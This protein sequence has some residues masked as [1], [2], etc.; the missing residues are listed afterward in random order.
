MITYTEAN[1]QVVVSRTLFV[2]KNGSD[3]TGLP[4]R[5]DKPFLTIEGAKNS[6]LAFFPV[7]TQSNRVLIVVESGNY[8]DQIYIEDFIDYDLGNSV[9]DGANASIPTVYAPST[10]TY[11]ATTQGIPNCII[12]GNATIRN[13]FP[14]T[15]VVETRGDCKILMYCNILRGEVFEAI[16]MR[17]GQLVVYANII[18]NAIQNNDLRQVINLATSN[19]FTVPTLEVNGAKIYNRYVGC[20]NSVIEIYNGQAGTYNTNRSKLTLNNC[21][22]GNFSANR[23]AIDLPIVGTD[24]G[25]ADIYLTNTI[26]YGS[27]PL[28]FCISDNFASGVD[29]GDLTIYSYSVYSNLAY[30]LTNP[31]SQYLINAPTVNANVNFNNNV[32][33]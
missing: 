5:L 15:A 7:R 23:S 13:S 18:H 11:T 24:K 19:T 26:I 32:I 31:S 16:L 9:I 2:S 20:I 1:T 10:T 14:N 27:D 29:R 6:A 33:I 8:I 3:A 30:D 17:T 4:E 28:L 25:Y 22:I 12:Y 21:Q